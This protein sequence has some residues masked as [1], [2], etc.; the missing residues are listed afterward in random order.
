MQF[1]TFIVD[2]E[3]TESI[4]A[5]NEVRKTRIVTNGLG[6]VGRQLDDRLQVRSAVVGQDGHL[7]DGTPSLQD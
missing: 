7:V 3:E 2:G 6:I 4:A 1:P 5:A